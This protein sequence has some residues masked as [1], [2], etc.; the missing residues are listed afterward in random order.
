MAER[1][2]LVTVEVRE[3]P[4]LNSLGD[5]CRHLARYMR[6]N[7]WRIH[8]MAWMMKHRGYRRYRSRRRR[9]VS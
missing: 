7:R 8:Q 3:K 4:L 2:L 5:V 1:E 9:Y 6:R